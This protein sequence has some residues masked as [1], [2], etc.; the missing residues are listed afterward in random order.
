MASSFAHHPTSIIHPS[1]Q[2][3]EFDIDTGSTVRHQFPETVPGYKNDWFAELM[4]PEGAHNR[5]KDW[6]YIFLNRDQ[7]Q[8]D[9]VCVPY[10]HSTHHLSP[11]YDVYR[12][13]I[14][15]AFIA[16]TIPLPE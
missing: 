13:L 2:L 8:I 12:P 14:Y 6:T 5:D 15:L 9:E 11:T 10:I 4:L 3:A 16:I 7:R 1:N